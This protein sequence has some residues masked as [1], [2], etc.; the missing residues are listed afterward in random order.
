MADKKLPLLAQVLLAWGV[1]GALINFISSFLVH[2]NIVAIILNL[3]SLIVFWS[4]YKFKKW[5]LYTLFVLLSISLIL[6]ALTLFAGGVLSGTDIFYAIA[7]IVFST[8]ILIYFNTPNIKAL[9]Q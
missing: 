5:A 4:V 7:G 1:I 6:S 2:F 9:F 3:I 8:L